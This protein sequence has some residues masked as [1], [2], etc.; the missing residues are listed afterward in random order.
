MELTIKSRKLGRTLTFFLNDSWFEKPSDAGYVFVDTNGKKG[1]LGEQLMRS[2]RHSCGMTA[3]E[4]TQDDFEKVCRKW[5]RH[6]I[7]RQALQL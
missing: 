1:C 2:T 5:L 7:Q 3:I 6:Y 4:S